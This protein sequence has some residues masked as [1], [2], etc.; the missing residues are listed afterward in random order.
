MILTGKMLLLLKYTTKTAEANIVKLKAVLIMRNKM[1]SSLQSMLNQ[2]S[3]RFS[4]QVLTITRT[5]AWVKYLVKRQQEMLLRIL[6]K[7]GR[8][9]GTLSGKSAAIMIQ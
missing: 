7:D 5:K 1:M 3:S 9:N 4:I 6:K 2:W 8:G